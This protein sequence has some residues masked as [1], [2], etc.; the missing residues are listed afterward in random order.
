MN[1]ARLPDFSEVHKQRRIAA[2]KPSEHQLRQQPLNI[3]FGRIGQGGL[4][5]VVVEGAVE[6]RLHRVCYGQG[7]AHWLGTPFELAH[8]PATDRVK[9]SHDVAYYKVHRQRLIEP[10]AVSLAGQLDSLADVAV[11]PLPQCNEF[12]GVVCFFQQHV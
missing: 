11:D 6:E 5:A 1:L 10:L 3:R 2:R 4:G 8:K 7:I 12:L 9:L